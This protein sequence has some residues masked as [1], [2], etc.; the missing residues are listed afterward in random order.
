VFLKMHG[1]A[2]AVAAANS[3]RTEDR[4]FTIDHNWSMD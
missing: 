1:V 3:A 2:A 4:P